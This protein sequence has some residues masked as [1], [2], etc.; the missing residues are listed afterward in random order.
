ML[1]IFIT[2]FLTTEDN[3]LPPNLGLK[4]TLFAL[5]WVHQNIEIFG[6]NKSE[7]TLMAHSSGAGSV[8][9]HL[10]SKQSAGKSKKYTL[11]T[12]SHNFFQC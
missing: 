5:K 11:S 12:F 3:F 6:G 9:Y 10:H 4:D 1:S 2:G 8:S 7:I